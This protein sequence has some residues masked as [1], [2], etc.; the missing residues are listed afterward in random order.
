[1]EEHEVVT[2]FLRY[3]THILLIKRSTTTS[4]YPQ[5]WGGISGYSE[6]TPDDAARWEITEEVGLD[7]QE[8][9]LIRSGEQVLVQD[10][11][12][13]I[14]W[15]VV[16]YLFEISLSP[17]QPNQFPAIIPN[18][19]ISEWD[20]IQPPEMFN[21]DT[22]PGLWNV[23]L[24]VAPS[25]ETIQSDRQHGSA[26]LSVRAMEV[27]RDAA[28]E[29]Y[30]RRTTDK[31][32]ASLCSVAKQLCTIRPSMGVISTRIDRIVHSSSDS[33]E[34]LY[35]H[36]LQECSNV[37]QV[38]SQIASIAMHRLGSHILTISDSGT[39]HTTLVL[40]EPS[41][42]YIM[43]SSPGREGITLAEKIAQQSQTTVTVLRDSAIRY[44]IKSKNVDT[45]I[46]GADSILSDGTIVNKIGT[47]PLV[48]VGTDANIDCY[49]LC[50]KDK[51]IPNTDIS[52]EE[53]QGPELY[54]GN[55]SLQAF[56]PAF[57]MIPYRYF[58]GILTELGMLNLEDIQKIA[59]EHAIASTWR[60]P[61]GQHIGENHD[62]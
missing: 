38:V 20:W 37:V 50:S 28:G 14:N 51:I 30:H 16:P 41:D 2:S 39:V 54:S 46:V 62:H 5:L 53:Y 1:M 40:T 34:D 58:D 48:T 12:N 47:G 29:C 21:K 23:Y 27:L 49:C 57:E 60:G 61:D 59:S 6:G 36:A 33:I 22:V 7:Q 26:Y 3:G 18:E 52:L 17:N 43:E 44:L 9:K 8:I 13:N 32:F 45:I 10:D 35:R 56:D 19:E 4:S 42:L 11:P 24:E 25:I 31:T 55:V 15:H